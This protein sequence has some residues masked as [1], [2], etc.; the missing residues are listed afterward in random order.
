[1]KNDFLEHVYAASILSVI[2]GC[3][4]GVIWL[5]TCNSPFA[6]SNMQV[7]HF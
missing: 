3:P 4:S 5:Y 7:L 1:M 6:K 2:F